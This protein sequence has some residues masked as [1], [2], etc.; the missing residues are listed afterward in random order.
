VNLARDQDAAWVGNT[1]ETGSH[2]DT[3]AV[4]VAILLDDDV[5]E[6]EPDTQFEGIRD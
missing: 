4:D 5:A 6:I 3:L 1:F 2:V